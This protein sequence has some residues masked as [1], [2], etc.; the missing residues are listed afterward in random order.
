MPF[1]H[2]LCYS[3]PK[4]YVNICYIPQ[5]C[6]IIFAVNRHISFNKIWRKDEK[7]NKYIDNFIF[8]SYSPFL[9]FFIPY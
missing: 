4:Y 5:D 6:V 8:T 3:Y 7:R 1:N 9:M 2:L